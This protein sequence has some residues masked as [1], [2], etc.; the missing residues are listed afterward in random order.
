MMIRKKRLYRGIPRDKT[1]VE[2][3]QDL[4]VYEDYCIKD[5]FN[6]FDPRTASCSYRKCEGGWRTAAGCKGP[7]AQYLEQ[8][9]PVAQLLNPLNNLENVNRVPT[10]FPLSVDNVGRIICKDTFEDEDK[11]MI[12]LDQTKSKLN[13]C[14][15]VID[16]LQTNIED[17]I[18][19]DL[20]NLASPTYNKM[21]DMNVNKK[22]EKDPDAYHYYHDQQT[23][24]AWTDS[25]RYLMTVMSRRV[26]MSSPIFLQKYVRR[27]EKLLFN[28]KIEYCS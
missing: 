4:S 27:V 14:N 22:I 12:K 16:G 20:F 3:I 10:S 24:H 25:Y 19:A 7:K 21:S 8:F 6:E 26:E 15:D 17:S 9:Y 11:C 28:H 1:D 13:L 18:D 5:V 2:Y 23:E